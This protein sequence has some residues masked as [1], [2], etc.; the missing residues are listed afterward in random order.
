M[1]IERMEIGEQMVGHEIKA[2]DEGTASMTADAGQVLG[3][4]AYGIGVQLPGRDGPG[5]KPR[6]MHLGLEQLV[7]GR[8]ETEVAA[9]DRKH[10]SICTSMNGLAAELTTLGVECPEAETTEIAD[11]YKAYG[12][13]VSDEAVGQLKTNRLFLAKTEAI[14]RTNHPSANDEEVVEFMGQM[15]NWVCGLHLALN[16]AKAIM[17]SPKVLANADLQ[18]QVSPMA[19][20]T[21]CNA[22]CSRACNTACSTPCTTCSLFAAWRGLQLH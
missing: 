6:Q 8:A 21:A 22:A 14:F 17:K 15:R 20:S 1:Q 18:Q 12:N 19:C 3:S 4:H 2:S 16:S 9:L 7:D 13:A 5:D 10:Q 11:L